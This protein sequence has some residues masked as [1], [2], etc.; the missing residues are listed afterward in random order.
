VIAPQRSRRTWLAFFAAVLALGLTL[1][2]AQS[3]VF[4]E[5]TPSFAPEPADTAPAPATVGSGPTDPAEPAEDTGAAGADAEDTGAKGAGDDDDSASATA[6]VAVKDGT[7]PK[8]NPKYP[9]IPLPDF[10]DV[11]NPKVV[12]LPIQGDIDLGLSPFVER[13]L[14]EADSATIVILDVDTFGGRVDAAVQIRDAL[15]ATNTPTLAYINRR[16]ISA[17][18]LIS[19]GAD[20]IVFAPGGSM[21]AATPIQIQGGEATAVDEKMTSYM[22]SEMRASAEAT[23]RDPALAEAMVDAT[24]AVEGIIGPEKLLTATTEEAL[25]MGL[26]DAQFSTMHA[27]LDA[28]GLGSAKQERAATNWA[29]MLARFLTNPAVAGILM[30]LGMLGLFVELK[31]PGVG[32]PGAVGVLCMA[33]FFGGH[34]VSNLAGW[35]EIMIFILGFGLLIVELF[36][37]PGFG[38]AGMLGLLFI[39]IGLVAAMFDTPVGV[40]WST[41]QITSLLGKVM[42]SFTAAFIGLALVARWLPKS[43]FTGGLILRTVVGDS[44][45]GTADVMT[46]RDYKSAPT[47][48]NDLVGKTGKA[49]TDLRMAGKARIDG[50]LIDVVSE[51]EYIDGGTPIRVLQVEGIRVVVVRDESGSEA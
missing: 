16:A 51:S 10:Q 14:K 1:G 39:S 20:H 4:A 44:E 26:A 47:A 24:V 23:G 28:I 32:L 35:E 36:I 18:A 25:A 40:A 5:E 17:G 15:L 42:L 49:E 8:A 37:I 6:E 33:A 11:A 9:P 41:G 13:V 22:R 46:D 34:L 50:R 19:L 3:P 2:L 7:A 38:V 43:K 30:S 21:G 27:L 48:L 29:E 31:S 12:V 45:K